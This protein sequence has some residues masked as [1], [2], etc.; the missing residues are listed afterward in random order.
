MAQTFYAHGKLLL[1]GEYVVLDGALALGLPT[2]LG[3]QLEVESDPQATQLHWRSLQ[4]D[5]SCWLE[6]TL[7]VADLSVKASSDDGGARRLQQVLRAAR[8]LS[9]GRFLPSGGTVTT[10]LEFDR[11]WGLGSSST[12]LAMVAEWAGVDMYALAAATFGGSG[13][14][15][16]CARAQGPILYQKRDGR[17]HALTLPFR[18]PFADQLYFIYSGAKQDSREGI[19]HYR[20][21]KQAPPVD[22]ISALSLELAHTTD[23]AR[24]CTLLARHEDLIGAAVGMTSIG[25]T[26][27][28][29]APGTIKS[30]G[31]WGGDFVLCA[32]AAPQKEVRD[33]FANA[34][35]GTVLSYNDLI[36]F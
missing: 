10:R 16:A 34:G 3:Q 6:V 13:Y 28:A 23:F 32:S 36:L 18:P 24:F 19:R 12:L 14:D 25:Q 1:T 35:C 4:P 5:G 17:G 11:H 30:L 15:L 31:A 8:D 27:F 2:R 9:G 7:Q 20:E 21:Q 33:Y 22:A 26:R 29:Q